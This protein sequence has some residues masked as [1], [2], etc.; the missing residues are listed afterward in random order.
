V[1]LLLAHYARPHTKFLTVPVFGLAAR[2]DGR[3]PRLIDKLTR[4]QLLVLDVWGSHGLTEQQRGD[5]LEIFEERYK[6][7]STLITAQLPVAQWH[8][9][10]GQPTIADA[11]LDRLIHNAHRIALEGES[12][13]KTRAPSLLTQGEKAEIIAA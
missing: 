2:L 11:I 10:I 6:R 13:R 3:F 9:M 12:M 7:K 8:E 1:G 4:V 5:L